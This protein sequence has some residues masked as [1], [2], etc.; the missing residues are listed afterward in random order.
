[1]NQRFE[2]GR[3]I[4]RDEQIANRIYFLVSGRINLVQR[5]TMSNSIEFYKLAGQLNSGEYTDVTIFFTTNLIRKF[6]L[7]Y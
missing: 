2:N 3:I 7:E 6:R 5:I 4:A 1:L